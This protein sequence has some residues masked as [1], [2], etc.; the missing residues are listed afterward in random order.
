MT[1]PTHSASDE[2]DQARV[3]SESA[4]GTPRWMTV[5]GIAIGILVI[6]VL[7]VLHLTG[8]MGSGGN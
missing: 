1:E 2:E 5:L 8:V 6:L 7:V 4:A 3:D